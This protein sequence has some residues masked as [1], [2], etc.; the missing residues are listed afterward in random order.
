LTGH[1][2][3]EDKMGSGRKREERSIG[4]DMREVPNFEENLLCKITL[5]AG[6]LTGNRCKTNKK[7]EVKM[8]EWEKDYLKRGKTGV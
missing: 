7:I 3:F 8:G 1:H 6:H 4:K 5:G 2:F